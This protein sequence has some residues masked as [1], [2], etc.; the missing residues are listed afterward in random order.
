MRFQIPC[1]GDLHVE[2]TASHEAN[3]DAAAR[4]RCTFKVG[5]ACGLVARREEL[6]MFDGAV[7]ANLLCRLPEPLACLDG[8]QQLLKPGGIAVIVTPFSWL[9]QFTPRSK[10]L[11][12]YRDPVSDGPVHSK[13]V[14]KAEMEKR[15][16][17]KVDQEQMPLVIR[18]HQRKYQ[19]IV[20]EA[21]VWRRMG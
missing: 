18:E 19:Y 1:E 10:W 12:G 20:S 17:V 9:D 3:V 6:G 14:L 21:T 13:E 15:G 4:A 7:L 8:L 11:G 5:D 16:F 2:V